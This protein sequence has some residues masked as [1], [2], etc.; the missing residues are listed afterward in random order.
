M[1]QIDSPN[2]VASFLQRMGRTGRRDGATANCTFLTTQDSGLL[3][4]AALVQLYREGFVEPVR[5]ISASQS[6]LAH[7]LM[8]LCIQ[9]GGAPPGDWW[10]W[11]DGATSF[12]ELECG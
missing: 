9:L 8:S 1:L 12:A 7:Q 10:A 3:Q 5:P 4:A 6:H 11:L 2:S